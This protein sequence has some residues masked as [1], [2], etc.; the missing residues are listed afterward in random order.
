MNTESTS[1][2]QSTSQ[3]LEELLAALEAEAPVPEAVK[4]V[5]AGK[6]DDEGKAAHAFAEARR[7][8]KEA[9]A[10]IRKLR[11]EADKAKNEKAPATGTELP[12]QQSGGSN[13]GPV[14]MAAI[15]KQLTLQ[16]MQGLGLYEI[17]T[18]EEQ[19]M[20]RMETQRLY[21]DHIATAQRINSARDSAPMVIANKLERYADKLGEA[22]MAEV[23][24]RLGAFPILQQVEDSVIRS[25]AAAYLGELQMAGES[26]G[27]GDQDAATGDAAPYNP[28]AESSRRV[29]A[30]GVKG[31]RTDLSVKAGEGSRRTAEKPATPEEMAMMQKLHMSDLKA[32]RA[33]QASKSKYLNR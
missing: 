32:F 14:N 9:A 6:K 24:R 3:D 11:E 30:A 1:T 27:S 17:K 22:G 2:T 15:L 28:A 18:P 25:V 26:S 12:P 8:N 31:G 33:A 21:S 13:V 29:A 5:D 20:V 16:A 10:L 7:K 4:A 19:E 23:K